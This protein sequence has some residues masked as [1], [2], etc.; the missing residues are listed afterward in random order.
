MIDSELLYAVKS[1]FHAVEIA[2]SKE[3]SVAKESYAV[4]LFYKSVSEDGRVIAVAANGYPH[5]TFIVNK[6][7]K[8]GKTVAEKEYDLGIGVH[9]KGAANSIGTA[10]RVGKYKTFHKITF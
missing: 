3:Y 10:V 6:A 7:I 9:I 4:G 2:V 8:V 5:F 1:V